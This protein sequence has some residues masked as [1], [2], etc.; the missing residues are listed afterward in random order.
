MKI[1]S[2]HCDYITFKPVK[3]ALKEPEK[4][5]SKKEKKVEEC[6]VILTAVEKS[7]EG[8]KNILQQYV[9]EIQDLAK[10]VSCKT[11]VLYPYAHLSSQLASPGFA[12]KLMKDAEKQLKKLK[13]GKGKGK[14]KLK[15]ERAPFGYYKQFELKCKGHPLAE[16]SREITSEDKKGKLKPEETVGVLG[17]ESEALKAE[18]KMKSYWH[19]MAPD[20]KLHDVGK[21]K[22]ENENLKKFA[23]YE[24]AKSR[25][26][27]KQPVH[28]KL[29]KAHELVDYEPASDLG[30]LR[31]YPK[32]RL[33]KALIEN[34]VSKRVKQYGALEVET[35]IMYDIN[36]PTLSKYLQRFPARQY[37]LASD[38]RN[39]FLRF[40]ACFG[41]FLIA[42]DAAISYKDLPLKL[43]ELTKY[44]FRKE[45]SGELTG[46]RRLRAFTMPDVH[47]FCKDEKQALG[48]FETRFRLSLDVQ[49]K[50]G[51]QKDDLELAIRFTKPFYK[52]NKKL[53]EKIIKIWN[54]PALIEMWDERFFYFTLKYEFN[55]IDSVDK[56][57]AL[58]TDQ[59][60]VENAERY[61][62]TYTDKDNKKKHPLILHCSP[63]GAVER[64]IYALLEKTKN[65]KNPLF[66][67]WLAPTQVRIL[68]LSEK[69][70]KEAELLAKELNDDFH[71]RTDV[72]DRDLPLS[73]KV[74]DAEKEWIPDVITIGEKELKNQV[75]A[76]RIRKKDEAKSEVKTMKP[77][78]LKNILKKKQGGM[79]WLPLPLPILLSKRP[80]FV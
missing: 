36:H 10:Q 20:G 75:L 80:R 73:K 43:Y 49:E 13:K 70:V 19:I 4:L 46:L 44:S 41:Q 62:I 17:D 26:V 23:V 16:L 2:L 34:Y 54:K 48:E 8:N 38:K 37:Q 15:V 58:S 27:V 60:D 1:L 56:A 6:L 52:K 68:P 63:S 61:N 12:E 18:T 55:F 53:I 29:M 64:V 30:N 7:D 39:F 33:I 66:P 42:K 22:Y 57:A 28:V 11:V 45:Q 72:D 32:G 76:V 69:Y 14:S 21:F 65:Q 24:K 59:I 40:A 9:A 78:I 67:Y 71:I 50:M 5:V 74:S 79:P 51:L 3:K 25:K 31:Y 77:H 35:P 47:A